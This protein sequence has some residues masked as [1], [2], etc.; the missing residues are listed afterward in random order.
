M[1]RKRN[2]NHSSDAHAAV[3]SVDVVSLLFEQVIDISQIVICQLDFLANYSTKLL[4]Y[5]PS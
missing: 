1:I 5:L 4:R 2:Q 3:Y